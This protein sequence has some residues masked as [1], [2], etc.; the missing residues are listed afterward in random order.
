[1][2]DKIK[3]YVKIV[4]IVI[5]VI[6]ILFLV[7]IESGKDNNQELQL[8]NLDIK[9]IIGNTVEERL[10]KH[11]DV[12]NARITKIENVEG[13]R[14]KYS[15]IFK[16]AENGNY[17]VELPGRLLVYDFEHD[18]IIAQFQLQNINLGENKIE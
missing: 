12:S 4:S 1:M 13:L 11:V 6:A 10:S 5:G 18:E 17:V 14:L 7:Y 2:N 3:K 8:A 9:E 15:A 16:D